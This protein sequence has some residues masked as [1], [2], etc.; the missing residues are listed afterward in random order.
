GE[1]SGVVMK[2]LRNNAPSFAMRS[3]L[4]DL[5]YGCPTQPSSSHR[6]SS[7]SMNTMLGRELFP[8]VE[9]RWLIAGVRNTNKIYSKRCRD[10]PTI[11]DSITFLIDGGTPL[12]QSVLSNWRSGRSGRSAR[13]RT[14]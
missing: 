7:M 12:H 8:A 2:A 11:F 10:V 1:Q 9:G 3:M 5:M 6:R 13:L 14:R 4:G